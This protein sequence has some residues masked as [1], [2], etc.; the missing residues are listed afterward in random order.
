MAKP[1]HLSLRQCCRTDWVACVS[2]DVVDWMNVT[3]DDDKV[4]C[5]RCL[6]FIAKINAI[7]LDMD[8]AEI[9][10]LLNMGTI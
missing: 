8:E 7:E 4:T 5:K 9:K 1:I 6:K 2:K 3:K 10:E